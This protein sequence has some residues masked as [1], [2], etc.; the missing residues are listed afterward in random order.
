[1]SGILYGIGIGPGDPEL[2]TLKGLRIMRQCHLI[3]YP[4]PVGK[5][6]LALAIAQ[7]HIG[8]NQQT[9]R[10]DI[11]MVR[12]ADALAQA[13][14]RAAAQ[15]H[16]HLAAGQNIAVLC[17]GD[18]QFYGSFMY[19]QHRLEPHFKVHSIPGVSSIMAGASMLGK[20]LAQHDEH[21][22]I[23]PATLPEDTLCALL[24]NIDA[25]VIIKIGRHFEKISRLIAQFGYIERCEYVSHA[26]MTQ[27]KIVSLA[28]VEADSCPYFS[29]I[30][31]H[32]QRKF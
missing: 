11:P 30:Y 26:T 10:F 13:Y 18:P 12:N 2:I 17:E 3:A 29:M 7:Q 32:A 8:A 19:L 24:H 27:Q 23:I 21:V 25:G 20:P 15:L 31:I 6:S 28:E 4:A 16:T 22:R 1:M 9:W 5:D 14:D